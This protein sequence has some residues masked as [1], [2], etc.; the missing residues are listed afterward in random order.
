MIEYEVRDRIAFLS[1]N[2]P[3]KHNALRDSDIAELNEVVSRVDRDDEVDVGIL[4]GRGP[5]FSSGAD[6]EDRLQGSVNEG[7]P[8]ARQNEVQTFLVRSVN[9]KPLIAAVHGYVMGHALGSALLC[10]FLIADRDSKLQCTEVTIGIPV[11]RLWQALAIHDQAFANDVMMTGRIFSAEEAASAGLVTRLVSPGNTLVEAE[12]FARALL[13]N[14]QGAV[15]E[16]VRL[17]R[18][19]IAE[20]LQHAMSVGGTYHWA[21]SAEASTRIAEKLAKTKTKDR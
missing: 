10:D 17:R 7:S 1:F 11:P 12:E 19:V 4:F 3:E 20:A 15:R 8:A 16:L 13:A 2:R 5:S 9:W 6:V 14:P 18:S 21:R